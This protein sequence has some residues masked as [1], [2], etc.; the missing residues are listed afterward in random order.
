MWVGESERALRNI[1]EDAC[2]QERALIFFDEFDSIGGQRSER[3]HEAS[4]HLVAQLLTLMDGFRQ[5]EHVMVLAATNRIG[6]IDSALRRP[7]RFD[8]ELVFP[9]PSH[10]DRI[11]ILN[12]SSKGVSVSQGLPYH[13]IA[14]RTDGW[15]G[16]DLAAIWREC[17]LLAATEGRSA[18]GYPPPTTSRRGSA[19]PAPSPDPPAP[20]PPSPEP[21][22]SDDRGEDDDGAEDEAVAARQAEAARRGEADEAREAEA[23]A[24]LRAAEE[25]RIGAL[26]RRPAELAEEADRLEAEAHAAAESADRARSAADAAALHAEATRDERARH[27]AG[28]ASADTDRRPRRGHL[29]GTTDG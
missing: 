26:E 3:A 16:A 22:D 14:S 9:R 20:A 13:E 1:F 7:G 23:A 6:D 18:V 25:A 21:D 2:R 10:A 15:T 12:K 27:D 17:R 11:D 24:R 4:R 19:S 28:E 29:D 8:W 5:Y